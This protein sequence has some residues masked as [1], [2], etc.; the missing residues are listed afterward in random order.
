[1]TASSTSPHL[2]FKAYEGKAREI[3]KK[4]STVASSYCLRNTSDV[5][6]IRYWT[7]TGILYVWSICVYCVRHIHLRLVT[8]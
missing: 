6:T 7:R 2:C 8:L 5:N 1:V 4:N 3:L